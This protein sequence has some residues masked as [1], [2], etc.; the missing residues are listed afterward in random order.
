MEEA[1]T[2]SPHPLLLFCYY[3]YYFPSFLVAFPLLPS[4]VASI[5]LVLP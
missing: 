1:V 2:V 5:P 3:D 4:S